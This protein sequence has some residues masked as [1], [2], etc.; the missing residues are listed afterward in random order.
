MARGRDRYMP[1]IV[2]RHLLGRAMNSRALDETLLPKRLALPVFCSDPLSS[3][4]YATQEILLVLVV[5]GAS[6]LAF[7]GWI[8]AAVVLLMIIVVASYRQTV[9]AYPSGGGAY[10]VSRD[11]LGTTAAL[12][13]ASALLVDYVMTVAVSVTSGVSNIASA[14]PLVARHSVLVSIV[15]VV[16]LA[17]V[18]L[19][20]VRESGT[21]FAIPTYGFVAAVAFLLVSAVIAAGAGHPVEAPSAHL[22]V[23]AS[24]LA[25]LALLFVVLRAFASGC[26]ALTGV[27]AVSNGVPFFRRPKSRNA[28][29]TLVLMA[30]LAIGMFVGVTWLAMSSGVKYAEDPATLGLPP[31]AEQP[32]VIAQ[33]GIAVFGSHGIGF[34]VLQAFTA[35]ILILAANTAFNGFPVLAS[36]LGGDGFLPRQLGRRGDRLVF[37]NGIIILTTIAVLLIYWYDA[38]PTRLI[39][40]YIV[41]VFVSFTL[42]QAGM[43][44]HW[45]RLL[46]RPGDTLT[47]GRSMGRKR[48]LNALGAAMT[49]VVLVVV[50]VSKFTH[51]AWM[52]VIAIPVLVLVMLGIRRHYDN[53]DMQLVAPDGGVVLP[54]RIHAIV[55]VARVNAPMMRAL[56]FA[57]ASRPSSLVCLHVS[58]DPAE[59]AQLADEWARR[60][61][62]APLVLVDS[63]YRDITRP[64]L[65]YI[66]GLTPESPRDIVSVYVPEHVTTH[67]WQAALHNQSS[68]RLKTRLLFQPRVMVTSVPTLVE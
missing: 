5:A 34:Y 60:Q 18:N 21:L 51:G 41:G 15:V 7:T 48:A 30:A 28:S 57:R 47:G 6:A 32:T 66:A 56:A 2:K 31:G 16:V 10:A 35:A 62:S 8:A 65:E 54:S 20:G 39:Q 37:S 44:V 55:L 3:V 64:V 24:P 27:E 58:T 14:F 9:Y 12:V 68:L 17:F 61:L 53:I 52:V 49:S 36:I 45:T 23:D 50:M 25:G 42:S 22:P 1:S 29:A 11:N 40:L 59:S 63:P 26:T 4:A 13:A 38:S 46:R 43:V 33:L 67:W 19:R